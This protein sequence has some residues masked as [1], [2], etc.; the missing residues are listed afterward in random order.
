MSSLSAGSRVATCFNC[1]YQTHKLTLVYGSGG[2][3]WRC[4]DQRGC[5]ARLG[6][7]A[8]CGRELD[9][10]DMEWNSD[11]SPAGKISHDFKRSARAQRAVDHAYGAQP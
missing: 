11:G 6:P 9:K 3:F 2:T 1:G 4:E 7:C 5:R 10:H 8:D